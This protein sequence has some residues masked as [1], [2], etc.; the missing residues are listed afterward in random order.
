MTPAA[1][2]LWLEAR[3]FGP[4]VTY[5]EAATALGLIPPGTIRQLADM[6]EQLMAEDAAAGRPFIAALV[7]GRLRDLPGP[8]FFTTAA[9]LGRFT[10]APDGPEAAAF[11]Q[12]E[13]A[14]L[15]SAGQSPTTRP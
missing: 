3:R 1:L 4:P 6:L 7:V 11:H 14:A 10:G 5:A 2:R 9:R 15:A 8:G 13:L 12:A